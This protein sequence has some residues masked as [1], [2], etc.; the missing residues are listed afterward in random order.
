M[1]TKKPKKGQWIT[2]TLGHLDISVRGR[3]TALYSVQFA[4]KTSKG[5]NRLCLFTEDWK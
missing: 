1:K 3:V 5:L 2:H 4:Y